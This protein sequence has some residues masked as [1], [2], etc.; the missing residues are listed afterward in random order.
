MQ[1]DYDYIAFAGTQ[2]SL[3]ETEIIQ[4]ATS[5]K[6]ELPLFLDFPYV[7][8]KN[9]T[10]HLEKFIDMRD[11]EISDESMRM[12]TGRPRTLCYSIQL[13]ND[14]GE[15][16]KL[17][18]QTLLDNAILASYNHMR[19]RIFDRVVEQLGSHENKL[20]I[21]MHLFKITIARAI[22]SNFAVTIT[23]NSIYD[24]VNAGIF[25]VRSFQGKNIAI[26]CEPLGLDVVNLLLK[27][28]E[29]SLPKDS[30]A[31][32]IALID[33]LTKAGPKQTKGK[34]MEEIVGKAL[35]SSK[36][37]SKLENYAV[38]YMTEDKSWI[39]GF[40]FEKIGKADELID[41]NFEQKYKQDLKVLE[42]F[43]EGK[44]DAMLLYPDQNFG[45]DLIGMK[46]IVEL[47]KKKKRTMWISTKILN[48]VTKEE[49]WKAHSQ[50]NPDHAYYCN[51]DTSPKL[52]PKMVEARNKFD[53]IIKNIDMDK[54]LM[55][56]VMI[57]S[58]N[59]NHRFTKENLKSGQVLITIT[60]D[61]INELIEDE[62]LISVFDMFRTA[63]EVSS[64]G[65]EQM[66]EYE[67]DQDIPNTTEEQ[68]DD[69]EPMTESRAHSNNSDINNQNK[70][71]VGDA[72]IDESVRPRK[73]FI[74][75]ETGK[76]FSNGYLL[77]L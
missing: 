60:L 33:H 56:N 52:N 30:I 71:K 24:Y 35:M 55:V 67:R 26:P 32:K 12:L 73:I 18:K 74:F 75:E 14:T 3:G 65:I 64:K 48:Q 22:N 53:E 69:D 45:P 50:M 8:K 40:E 13:L 46:S 54:V 51:R 7:E 4:S 58:E 9:I 17:S 63:E 11:C 16:A 41:V 77:K 27:K 72:G 61:N 37:V 59:K 29:T 44:V 31:H 47:G 21:V 23:K 49:S 43:S 5:R 28:F 15:N 6:N 25:H 2:L 34:I 19:T 57:P 42:M 20:K 39:R 10:E 70:R 38:A 36:K 62:T 1:K 68:D 66:F 76:I